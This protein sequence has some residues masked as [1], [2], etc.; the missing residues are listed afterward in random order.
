MAVEE[1][2]YLGEEGGPEIGLQEVSNRDSDRFGGGTVHQANGNLGEEAE[3]RREGSVGNSVDVSQEDDV[4]R[5][6][7]TGRSAKMAT[8][9]T[10]ICD[11]VQ[12]SQ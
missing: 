7:S 9:L 6:S 1:G 3:T 4:E 2:V 5:G 8:K 12:Q 11:V 10:W